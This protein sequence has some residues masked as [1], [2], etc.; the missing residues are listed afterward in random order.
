MKKTLGLI[1]GAG[2]LLG[3]FRGAPVIGADASP[4]PGDVL[5]DLAPAP[6]EDIHSPLVGFTLVPVGAVVAGC[7]VDERL[8]QDVEHCIRFDGII[9]NLGDGPFEVVW[10]RD[11]PAAD[12]RAFQRV[13]RSD[14]GRRDVPVG[15]VRFHLAHQHDHLQA[16]AVHRLFATDAEGAKTGDAL[17][18]GGKVGYCLQDTDEVRPGSPN[19]YGGGGPCGF[20]EEVLFGGSMSI[21]A[22]WADT[23]PADTPGQYLDTEG[24]APGRY[25]LETE[26]DPDGLFVESDE[27]NNVAGVAFTLCPGGAVVDDAPCEV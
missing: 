1:V 7:S 14:G 27:T 24:L 20:G 6:P 21:S 12:G 22:G 5:P 11:A 26:V 4:Q 23:Y 17:R 15:D 2:V 13:R 19:H 3:L 8:E 18:V 25:W 10:D 16:V 9:Q